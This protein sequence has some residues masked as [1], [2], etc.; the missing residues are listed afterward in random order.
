VAWGALISAACPAPNSP[1]YHGVH[2]WADAVPG[3]NDRVKDA[4]FKWERIQVR[5]RD[6]ET[7]PGVYDWTETDARISDAH[8]HGFSILVYFHGVPAWANGGGDAQ[9]PPTGL[10]FREFTG[11]VAYR[12]GANVAAFELWNEP[13]QAEFWTGSVADYQSKILGPGYDGI[14]DAVALLGISPA[15]VLAPSTFSKT[16]GVDIDQWIKSGGSLVR[17]LQYVSF[18]AYGQ[19]A[20]QKNSI[21]AAGNYCRDH[22]F[23]F[24]TWDTEGGFATYD[25]GNNLN[26]IDAS[27]G[28]G[29]VEV[30][31][32]CEVD[33]YCLHNFIY[34]IHD[35]DPSDS[36]PGLVNNSGQVR[37]RLCTLE[38]HMLGAEV[39]PCPCSPG[40]PGCAGTP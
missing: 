32:K 20:D 11:K 14:Q 24:W 30:Q 1:D 13:D 25:N 40:I 16:G 26:Y 8:A 9:T 37:H 6:V 18:H 23:C 28:S 22:P 15:I 17:P 4:G 3:A 33:N 2:G 12:H 38:D 35:L 21:T 5:W 34:F 36:N 27:P 10:Q 31:T 29:L 39:A 7:A 19:R